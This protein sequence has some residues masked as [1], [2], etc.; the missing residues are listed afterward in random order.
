MQTL[1]R[2]A[3][4]HINLGKRCRTKKCPVAL[5]MIDAGVDK[6]LL[7]LSDS[8]WF[9]ET[10]YFV[11]L[12]FSARD[13]IKRFDTEKQV[14]PFDFDFYYDDSRLVKTF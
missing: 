13:F 14:E 2:V 3:R 5:A 12:P 6:S 4:E 9:S 10:E 7:V 11:E 8:V 1:I